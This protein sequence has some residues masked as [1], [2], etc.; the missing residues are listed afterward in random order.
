MTL[1]AYFLVCSLL[2]S[3]LW[4]QGRGHIAVTLQAASN[5]LFPVISV[6]GSFTNGCMHYREVLLSSSDR[7]GN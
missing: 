4:L 5:E 2:N 3:G 7:Q 1:Q 6:L